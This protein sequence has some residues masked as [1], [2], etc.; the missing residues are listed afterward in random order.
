MNIAVVIGISNYANI[1]S[2]P[3]CRIDAIK[4]KD[5][6]EATGKYS[7]VVSLTN[8]TKARKIKS[9][10]RDFF[11]KYK[12]KQI[13]EVFFYFSGHGTYQNDVLFCCSDFDSKRPATTSLS[14]REIDDLIRSVSP[15]LAVK[16]LDACSSGAKY[17]KDTIETFEKVFRSAELESF[18]CMAS[19]HLNQSSYATEKLSDFTQR[20]IKGALS[21]DDGQILYRDI[22]SYISD[23]F[24]KTP[25]QSPFFVSQ[26]TGLEVFAPVTPS[27]ISL[28]QSVFLSETEELPADLDTTIGSNIEELES[29]F[30][31][32]DEV[33]SSL[34]TLS[35]TLT[36]LKPV[37]PLISK[38]YSYEFSFSKKIESLMNMEEI[39]RWASERKWSK[40]YF[41]DIIT[42]KRKALAFPTALAA[43]AS[44][45]YGS[46]KSDAGYKVESVPINVK[47]THPLPF[48]TIEIIARP[49]KRSLKQLGA[50]IGI[51]H[52]R[53]DALILSTTIMYKDVGW[54]ER[55]IDASTGEWTIMELKWKDIVSNPKIITKNVLSQLENEISDY[56][57]SFVKEE[58]ETN[59]E[60]SKTSEDVN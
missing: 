18:I 31:P 15:K 33:S 4:M 40:S 25:E 23:A 2:L 56:L 24:I 46:K 51:V 21:Q 34:E 41:V 57:K 42:E 55:V 11:K 7:E 14:N 35:K 53:T 16:V 30:V 20:F 13:D 49:N 1:N 5:L 59:F 60:Q 27:M 52:S 22:Q 38:Y 36:T 28:K 50:L 48:E 9:L 37:D 12:D 39:A 32:I 6:L 44:L 45:F 54:D 3:A 8:D 29:F 10:L 47:S 26:G 58:E 17:I 43:S 19:S